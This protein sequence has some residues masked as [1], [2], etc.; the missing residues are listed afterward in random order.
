MPLGL[1]VLCL[2]LRQCVFSASCL[3]L[4]YTP[5]PPLLL[6]PCSSNSCRAA[7]GACGTRCRRSPS[8][9]CGRCGRWRRRSSRA[10][11]PRQAESC[12]AEECLAWC[13]VQ[14]T[15]VWPCFTYRVVVS[16][17]WLSGLQV[18]SARW[19]QF[20]HQTTTALAGVP[21]AELALQLFLTCA[22]SASGTLPLPLPCLGS[23]PP[24]RSV[25]ARRWGSTWGA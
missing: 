13:I 16:C 5:P 10:G 18:G 19:Y 6:S 23:L 11:R 2:L 24:P 8:V 1:E 15:A 14:V 3:L 4:L 20:L 12:F 17:T 25:S 22:H 9:R 21:A 7:H